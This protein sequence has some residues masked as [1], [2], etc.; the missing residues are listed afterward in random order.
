MCFSVTDCQGKPK[1]KSP[2][3]CLFLFFIQFL[4]IA[5]TALKQQNYNIWDKIFVSVVIIIRART[6]QKVYLKKNQKYQELIGLCR[7]LQLY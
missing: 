7:V 1:I 2:I 4:S 3:H 5:E 6:N